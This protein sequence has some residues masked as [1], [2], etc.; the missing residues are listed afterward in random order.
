M[1]LSFGGSRFA[2]QKSIGYMSQTK[3]KMDKSLERISS[4]KRIINSSDDPGG[5]A[6]AMKLQNQIST[7]NAAIGRVDNAKS[8]V[9]MQSSALGTATDIL[10]EM[11]SVWQQYNDPLAND[12]TK[13]T[14]AQQ[15]R[16]LQAQLGQLKSEKFN[17][18]SLFSEIDRDNMTV[19]TS[20]T[21]SGVDLGKLDI[22]SA[23][24]ITN[25]QGKM[26]LGD[27][28]EAGTPSP[29]RALAP[30]SKVTVSISHVSAD[31]LDGVITEV[32]GL[33]TQAAGKLSTLEFAGD[34]LT[35]MSSTLEV[36][37]GRIMDVDLAEETANYASLSLQYEAAASAVVQANLMMGK[38]MSLLIGSFNDD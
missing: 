33:S 27:T 36:A 26:N 23:L 24:G 38:V 20:G 6:V 5:L 21:G 12:D 35:S 2:T 32:A 34:Y 16:D 14:L 18:V 22:T 19:A 9:E 8:F 13:E 11:S 10:T 4:G 31:D 15:F 29:N 28:T 30:E 37:H 17:G 7:N 3:S 25:E 1:A